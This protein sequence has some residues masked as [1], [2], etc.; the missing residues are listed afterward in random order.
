[1]TI[2]Q[3]PHHK[4]RWTDENRRLATNNNCIIYY[5]YNI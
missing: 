3:M 5:L 1:M 2:A 4:K